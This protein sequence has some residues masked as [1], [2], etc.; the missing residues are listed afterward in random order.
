MTDILVK[1]KV[2]GRVKGE[3]F[4]KT[5][6]SNHFLTQPPAIAFDVDSLEDARDAGASFVCVT[7]SDTG[8]VYR[9][10]LATIL[11]RGFRF[12]RGHGQQVA[13][14]L[15]AWQVSTITQ[16]QLPLPIEF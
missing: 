1:G 15:S 8:Q 4:Y 10:N 3:T 14:R 6:H 12:D 2:V 5:L 11:G 13:L 16:E 7:N 9:A